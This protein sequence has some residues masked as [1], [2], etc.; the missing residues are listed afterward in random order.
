MHPWP[1]MA[2]MQPAEALVE[3]IMLNELLQITIEIENTLAEEATEKL[4]PLLA[5][6]REIFA[7]LDL[8]ALSAADVTLLRSVRASEERCQV[9]AGIQAGQVQAGLTAVRGQR[10]LEKAYG[11]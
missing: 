3:K 10:R 2:K 11:G 8:Q 4:S 7:G 6:R 1:K 5:R 9:L